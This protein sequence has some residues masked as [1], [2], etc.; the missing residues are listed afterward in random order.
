M[1][2]I[3]EWL[4]DFSESHYLEIFR[5]DPVKKDPIEDFGYT[6]SLCVRGAVQG[7]LHGS[8]G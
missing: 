2:H 7:Y 3:K 6:V 4:S 1:N 5:M 8:G